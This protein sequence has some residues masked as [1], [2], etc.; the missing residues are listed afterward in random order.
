LVAGQDDQIDAAVFGAALGGIRGRRVELGIA[1]GGDAVGGMARRSRKSRAM[2]VARAEE[3][4]QLES[5]SA[6]WMGTLS[7]CPSMRRS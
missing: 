6:V 3:S 2:R 7:V 5:N 1:G 4:S